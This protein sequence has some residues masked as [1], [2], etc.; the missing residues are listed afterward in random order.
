LF[1]AKAHCHLCHALTDNQPDATLFIEHHI[2][3]GGAAPEGNVSRLRPSHL[4][5]GTE[6]IGLK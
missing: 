6:Q 5:D 1:N 2:S 4:A 3:Q